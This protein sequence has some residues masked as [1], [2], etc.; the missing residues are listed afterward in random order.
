M[1]VSVASR[2]CMG[3]SL[4]HSR[5]DRTIDGLC[6]QSDARRKQRPSA[7]SIY[8]YLRRSTTPCVKECHGVASKMHNT[9]PFLESIMH[10]YSL[11][12]HY[13][14]RVESDSKT[15]VTVFCTRGRR[16]TDNWVRP[17]SL[18]LAVTSSETRAITMHNCFLTTLYGHHSVLDPIV[19]LDSYNMCWLSLSVYIA[20]LDP[21]S[22]WT[23]RIASALALTLL[24]NN[25]MQGQQL[26]NASVF[27]A[28]LTCWN[29]DP[30]EIG[31]KVVSPEILT[32]EF[33]ILRASKT[34]SYS[35][36]KNKC[37]HP[38]RT[39]HITVI[40]SVAGN[41]GL[42]FLTARARSGEAIVESAEAAI[43]FT[44]LGTNKQPKEETSDSEVAREGNQGYKNKNPRQARTSTNRKGG[45]VD[46][47]ASV[48]KRSINCL[49]RVLHAD[50]I[51]GS[52]RKPL[53]IKADDPCVSAVFVVYAASPSFGRVDSL[54]TSREDSDIS[55]QRNSDWLICVYKSLTK[56]EMYEECA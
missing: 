21:L 40:S 29:H 22:S 28:T 26:S 24:Y 54:I 20:F 45:K 33:L 46:R 43:A 31:S 47:P 11:K 48:P 18:S 25:T 8:P 55:T 6:L 12:Y 32:K 42:T 5:I 49:G 4:L 50:Q 9:Q 35:P 51:M 14:S 2:L 3:T 34:S 37:I 23:C 27:S 1:S 44:R 38:H 7:R 39:N 19:H 36:S 15:E 41:L 53:L 16:L 17:L 13:T 56:K 52:S 10:F 30:E